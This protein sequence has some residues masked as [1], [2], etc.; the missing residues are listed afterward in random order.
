MWSL[1]T[2]T[3]IEQQ[4]LGWFCLVFLLHLI[5]FTIQNY[6]KICRKRSCS[7]QLNSRT[8]FIVISMCTWQFYHIMNYWN[9]IYWKRQ[10]FEFERNILWECKEHL[11]ST[12]GIVQLYHYDHKYVCRASK[13][14]QSLMIVE[15][16]HVKYTVILFP[17]TYNLVSLKTFYDAKFKWD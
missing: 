4:Q 6:F 16:V 8:A 1:R 14:V 17:Q 11:S 12:D 3:Y 7:V 9:I 5:M 15:F 13:I 2:V 10:I